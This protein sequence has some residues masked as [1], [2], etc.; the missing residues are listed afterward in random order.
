MQKTLKSEVVFTGVGLHCGRDVTLRVRP[1]AAQSG[2]WFRRTDVSDADPYI[3]ANWQCAVHTALCT[4]LVNA[5]GLGVSTVEHVMAA[6]AGCGINNAVV[7]LDG[8]EVPIMDGS[9]L[10][11]VRGFLKAGLIEQAAPVQVLEILQTVE[12]QE[13]GAY[14]ALM[15]FGGIEMDFSIAPSAVLAHLH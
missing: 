4:R 10:E 9:A 3:S 8:P 12:V 7:E 13:N 5:D 14:A 15:P 11:F 6:I 1:A 2:I